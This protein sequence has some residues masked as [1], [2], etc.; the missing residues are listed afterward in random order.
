MKK[1]I[2]Q[3]EVKLLQLIKMFFMFFIFSFKVLKLS[4]KCSYI[5]NNLRENILN[6]KN[7]NN[8]SFKKLV[9]R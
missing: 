3:L 6:L 1:L 2:E 4:E 8:V 7:I 5:F 9:R